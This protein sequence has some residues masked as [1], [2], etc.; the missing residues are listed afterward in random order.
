MEDKKINHEVLMVLP[1][2]TVYSKS[3]LAENWIDQQDSTDFS[4]M[5]EGEKIASAKWVDANDFGMLRPAIDFS[6]ENDELRADLFVALMTRMALVYDQTPSKYPLYMRLDEADLELI[7]QASRI[8]FVPYF[9][10]WQQRSADESEEDWK[11]ITEALRKA[12]P[13]PENSLKH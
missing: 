6:C 5:L 3:S 10:E 13:A 4:I 1:R 12:Y 8:G 2:R 9:G 7:A 11:R